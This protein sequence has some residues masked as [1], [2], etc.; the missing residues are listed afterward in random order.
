MPKA[1]QGQIQN[2]GYIDVNAKKTNEKKK[3]KNVEE[4]PTGNILEIKRIREKK[5]VKG[6]WI[7]LTRIYLKQ[8]QVV[9]WRQ[10]EKGTV[11]LQKIKQKTSTMKKQHKYDEDD[12]GNYHEDND[13]I[14]V[15]SSLSAMGH[16]LRI[17]SDGKHRTIIQ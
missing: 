14:Y 15:S 7:Q 4:K 17:L 5:K 1:E 11:S 3:K 9:N 2:D 6:Q 16:T 12:D 10:I 13:G 8:Y